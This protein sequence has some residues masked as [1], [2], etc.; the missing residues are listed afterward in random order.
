[1]NGCHGDVKNMRVKWLARSAAQIDPHSRPRP[2]RPYIEAHGRGR[3]R[4]VRNGSP[5]LGNARRCGTAGPAIVD[6]VTVRIPQMVLEDTAARDRDGVGVVDVEREVIL[7][8]EVWD[9]GVRVE[10]LVLQLRSVRG[11]TGPWVVRRGDAGG[12]RIVNDKLVDVV[13]LEVDRRA[14]RVERV[15]GDGD[16]V[17]LCVQRVRETGRPATRAH[18]LVWVV[19]H[20]RAAHVVLGF[21]DSLDVKRHHVRLANGAAQLKVIVELNSSLLVRQPHIVQVRATRAWR[22]RNAV[23]RRG[24]VARE[25]DERVHELLAVRIRHSENA[26]DAGCP[27]TVGAARAVRPG[28]AVPRAACIPAPRTALVDT[29]A[30]A[31]RTAA[32]AA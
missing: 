25:E 20:A 13:I 31:A 1:L 28:S 22:I 5:G 30:R 14:A 12:E 23:L 11:D 26:R 4:D 24:H 9:N 10:I 21:G 8:L 27:T 19:G 18:G 2:G 32:R 15:W 17:G 16:V 29:A 6:R 7:V 3:N